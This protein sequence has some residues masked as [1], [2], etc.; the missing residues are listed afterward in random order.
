MTLAIDKV[1]GH[2]LSNSVLFTPS[3]DAEVDAVLTIEG[4]A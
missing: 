1:D 3:K 2:G 4:G